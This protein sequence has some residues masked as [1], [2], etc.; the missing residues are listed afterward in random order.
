M[1]KTE[2]KTKIYFNI[3]DQILLIP[4]KMLPKRCGQHVLCDET[5]GTCVTLDQYYNVNVVDC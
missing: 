1:L 4:V 5:Y 3:S 2:S